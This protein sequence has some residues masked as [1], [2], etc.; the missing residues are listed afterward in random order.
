[1]AK[2]QKRNVTVALDEATARWARVQAARLDTSLSEYL[3]SLLRA[4]M[5][6]ERTYEDAMASWL[7]RSPTHLKDRPGYPTRGELHERADLR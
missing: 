5:Q 1:M 4:E 3:A 2:Q 7:R 6:Q